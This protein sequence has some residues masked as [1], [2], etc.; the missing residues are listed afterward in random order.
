VRI[1][2]SYRRRR[3]LIILSIPLVLAPLIYLG[4]HYSSPG[5]P[6]TATGPEFAAPV[7]PKRAPFTAEDR[8]AV[9][10]VLKKFIE[11]AVARND[12]SAAW[13]VSAPNLKEGLTRKQWNT[14]D[15][16]VVPYPAAN[17]GLGT[18][19]YVEYS[20]TNAVGLEVFVFPQPGSGYSAMTADVELVKDR[21]GRWLVDYWLPKRFHGPPALAAQT[22][23]K[24]NKD[25]GK[26]KPAR[27]QSRRTAPVP[28]PFV[29]PRGRAAD[30]WWTIPLGLLTLVVFVPALIML[31]F[32]FRNRRAYKAYLRSIA[33]R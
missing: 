3:R 2:S 14:G 4:V 6:E 32:W 28:E 13:D 12:V 9:R 33:E 26:T 30:Y 21:Q 1:F 5:N 19:S 15:I 27:A 29:P 31:F 10:P 17:R 16:P 24:V 25:K 11:T 8:R 22:A 20:Y 18:W 7:E 23:K